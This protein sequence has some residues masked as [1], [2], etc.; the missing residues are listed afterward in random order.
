MVGPIPG[1]FEHEG[2]CLNRSDNELPENPMEH[3][4]EQPIDSRDDSPKFG[5]LIVILILAV[6]M[7]GGITLMAE[8]YY[9]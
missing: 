4:E 5:R 1:H 9:S 8:A 2:V 6:L 7:I 3:P